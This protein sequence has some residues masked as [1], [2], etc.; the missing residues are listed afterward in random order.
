MGEVEIAEAIAL[1]ATGWFKLCFGLGAGIGAGLGVYY[2]IG[3]LANKVSNPSENGA[4][5]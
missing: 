5:K 3:W 1:M 4:G 2:G